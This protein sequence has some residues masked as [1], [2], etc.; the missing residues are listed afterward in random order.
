M[1]QSVH[2]E[3]FK[4]LNFVRI[5]EKKHLYIIIGLQICATF[6]RNRKKMLKA[7]VTKFCIYKSLINT[8]WGK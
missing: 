2:L 4:K 7:L 5:W 1:K 6:L 8:K 3:F